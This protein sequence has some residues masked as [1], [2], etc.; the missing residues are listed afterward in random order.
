MVVTMKNILFTGLLT[1]MILMSGCVGY[2][3]EHE[4]KL[5]Q[6][7]KPEQVTEP[8]QISIPQSSEIPEQQPVSQQPTVPEPQESPEQ[9][10]IPTDEPSPQEKQSAERQ[11]ARLQ[12]MVLIPGG[13]F[14]MGDHHGFGG[15]DP[16]HKSDEVPIHTV[17]IDPFYIGT[18]EVTT[19]Q[20]VDYLNSTLAQSLI[21]VKGGNVYAVGGSDIY[22]ETHES[23]PYNSI[24]WDGSAFT[25]LDNRDNHPMIGV[26]WHGAAAYTTWLNSQSGYPG[27]YDL[28]TWD[29]DFSKSGFRLPTEAEWEYAG[30]GGQHNPYYV[31]AWGD[32]PDNSRANWPKSGDPFETGPYPWTTPVGFYNG[33]L[34]HKSDFNWPDSQ[35]IYQTADGSN[36]YGLYDITGNVWEWCHDWYGRDYYRLSSKDNPQGP[37]S[38]SLM[39]DGKPYRVL[40]SGNWYN[41]QWGHSRVSNR[42]PAYYRGP[43]DP[44]HAWYHIGFRV[45]LSLS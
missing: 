17:H 26:R 25:V 33:Q 27:G 16:K 35:D 19:R 32:E 7:V 15:E 39:P 43:D 36:G 1:I 20:Y 18:T 3:Q 44:N 9:S 11:S 14:E 22:C 21:E 34:H 13:E 8:E 38:G 40:R 29:C 6:T 45:V 2:P 30:R 5:E 12:G 37:E 23:I 41:G 31:F 24:R 42:D 4:A 10:P 28:T